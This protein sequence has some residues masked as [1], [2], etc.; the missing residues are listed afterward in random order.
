MSM[1]PFELEQLGLDIRVVPTLASPEG[2]GVWIS[3]QD[4]E[5]QARILLGWLVEPETPPADQMLMALRVAGYIRQ[6]SAPEWV[7][8]VLEH[9][10]RALRT[11]PTD[12]TEEEDPDAHAE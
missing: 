6:T 10:L 11:T 12:T 5:I 8:P 1:M 4:A 9:L 7:T 2:L 3:E